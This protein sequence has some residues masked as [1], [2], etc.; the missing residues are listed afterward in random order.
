MTTA[1]DR[2][3][4]LA[5]IAAAAGVSLPTVSKVVNGKDDVAPATRAR[6]QQLLAEHNY[7]PV[8]TRRP[9]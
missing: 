3:A 9:G 7:V 6:V 2:R 5:T 8:S 1:S 4:T